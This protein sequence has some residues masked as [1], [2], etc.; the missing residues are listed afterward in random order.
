[1]AACIATVSL[2]VAWLLG[3]YA[4]HVSLGHPA[5]YS[6]A[7]LLVC[8]IGLVFI[9]LRKRL[10]MLPL[11]SVSTW[12]Q[13]HIYTG[14]FASVVY[15]V[16]VPGIFASGKFEGPLSCLFVT[17]SA[18][19]FYGLYISRTSPKR[20]TGIATQ[21]RF[22]RIGWHRDQ[23]AIAADKAISELA[24]TPDRHVLKSFYDKSMKPYF[25]SS[26]PLSY[27]IFPTSFSKRHLLSAMGELDR[28]LDASV[29][30][31]S[32]KLA[33]LVRHRDDLNYQHAIQIRLRAWV[34]IHAGLSVVL[35]V[36]SV[37]HAYLAI[38]MLGA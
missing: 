15:T 29:L 9:G 1:M 8:L 27:F 20:L 18:S 34:A 23:I 25:A 36:W 16:H 2:L 14:L 22:D 33:A 10:V 12:V 28:Y 5:I 38:G 37:V 19:G 30:S 6:G 3:A 35:V 17:V 26:L 7:T 31:V 32:G 24:D 13:I 21:V 4:I 11:W